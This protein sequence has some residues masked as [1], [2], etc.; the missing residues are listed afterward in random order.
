[1]LRF[2]SRFAL[3]QRTTDCVCLSRSAR[4]HAHFGTY[5]RIYGTLA[6]VVIR[7]VWFD[8]TAMPVL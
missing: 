3:N 7:R 8:M 2:R 6:G 4:L 1:L 5:A